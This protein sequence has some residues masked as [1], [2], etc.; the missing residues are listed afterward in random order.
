M[1]K[2]TEKII[3]SRSRV[4]TFDERVS[5]LYS[6]W[7]SLSA[8]SPTKENELLLK[9]GLNKSIV[10]NA[11]HLE[12]CKLKAQVNERLDK[13]DG[14]ENF[15]PWTSWKG[16]LE[17]YPAAVTNDRFANFKRQAASEGAHPPWVCS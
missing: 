13:R 16:L 9:L 14:N 1:P 12:N 7:S 2:A 8:E 5:L 11:P 6:A 10:P 17:T 4:K 3:D 15:P